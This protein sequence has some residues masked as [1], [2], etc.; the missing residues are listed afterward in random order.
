[1][2]KVR[3][4]V[5]IFFVKLLSE[6]PLFHLEMLRETQILEFTENIIFEFIITQFNYFPK[7]L[8]A[9]YDILITEHD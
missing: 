4:N 7:I 5:L 6:I 9:W 2:R 8:F 3:R 1:M